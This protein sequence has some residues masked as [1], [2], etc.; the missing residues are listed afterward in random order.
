MLSLD[1]VWQIGMA[2]V[3][4]FTLAAALGTAA[5]MGWI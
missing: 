3:L 5:A 1:L 4:V 2:F